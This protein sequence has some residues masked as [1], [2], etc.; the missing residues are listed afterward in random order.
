MPPHSWRKINLAWLKHA[1]RLVILCLVVAGIWRAIDQAAGE[2][3]QADLDWRNLQWKWLVAAG[4]FYLAGFVP[5]GFYWVNV[6]RAMGQ[7]PRILETMRAFYAGHLGKYVPGKA[8]VVVIRTGLIR[9]ERVDTTVAA[10]S[11]FVETLTLMAVGAALSAVL[12]GTLFRQHWQLCALAVAL[13]VCAAVP[14]WPPLFR[15]ILRILQVHR[16]NPK[17]DQ[18]LDGLNLKV[19]GLGWGGISL[20]WVLFG[21]S[22]WATLN[23][24]PGVGLVDI[25]QLP[26]LIACVALAIVAGFL[27]LLPGGLFVREFVVTTLLA[28]V[29][30]AVAA[31]V[32]AVLLRVVWL[33]S[34]VIAAGVLYFLVPGPT[35]DESGTAPDMSGVEGKAG[36]GQQQKPS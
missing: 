6:L 25:S 12:L 23:A 3:R 1:A 2:F 7:R 29:F 32:S 31:L 10:A 14:T 9:S 28:P 4:A 19:M 26:L 24:L 21:C 34:E 36:S 27:S 8:L 11:I 17:I 33:V 35:L 13:A 5:S 22:L 18:A 20:G 16:A 30:G 15:R